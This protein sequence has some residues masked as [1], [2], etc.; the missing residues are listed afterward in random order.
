MALADLDNGLVT[1]GKPTN[2]GCCY[3]SFSGAAVPTDASTPMAS[4]P[5]FESVG[6]VTEDGYTVSKSTTSNKFKGWHGSVI[7]QS[8]S[9][10]EITVKVAFA[11]INRPTVAKLRYGTGNV[12]TGADGSVAAVRAV[13]GS[14]VKVPLVFDELESNG[15]L[16]RTVFKQCTIDSFE[17]V[18]HQQGSLVVYG[19]T[20]TAL[21]TGDGQSYVIY[22]AKPADE[23]TDV[24]VQSVALDKQAVTVAVG[25]DAVLNATVTPPDATDARVTATSSDEK[26]AT[27]AV[28]GNQL[29]VHGAAATDAGKPVTVTASCGGKTA[30]C[31]VTVTAGN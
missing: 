16:R 23:P 26:K 18:A 9:D 30:T 10:E 8:I 13:V 4:V 21:D 22:R 25:T 11:E 5:G 19:M 29:T 3:T 6:E 14:N 7:L 2:G 17:D 31:A 15:Y 1:V 24:P 12:D 20:F 28:R 27:V